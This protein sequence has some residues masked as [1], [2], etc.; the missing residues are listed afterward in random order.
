M[1]KI[2]MVSNKSA[3]TSVPF[4]YIRSA[5]ADEIFKTSPQA[6][7]KSSQEKDSALMVT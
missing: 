1:S 3:P 2:E 4:L 7:K 5:G 6:N